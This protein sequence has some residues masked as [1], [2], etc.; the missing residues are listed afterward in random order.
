MKI[1]HDEV[2]ALANRAM[3][4]GQ[5]ALAGVL[6]AVAGVVASGQEL[7]MLSHLDSFSRDQLELIRH[8]KRQL[9]E[10]N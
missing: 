7:P 2:K 8:R 3:E 10:R 5:T 6:Y 1:S 4:N 9:T